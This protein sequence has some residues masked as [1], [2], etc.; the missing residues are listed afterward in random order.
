MGILRN[1]QDKG[2]AL[3]AGQTLFVQKG[4]KQFPALLPAPASVLTGSGAFAEAGAAAWQ[5][6]FLSDYF[7]NNMLFCS[8]ER[9]AI[10]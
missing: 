10:P 2:S 3:F 5:H 4:R 9:K 1:G 8:M 6:L 7:G